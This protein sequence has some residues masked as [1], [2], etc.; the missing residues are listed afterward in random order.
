MYPDALSVPLPHRMSYPYRNYLEHNPLRTL[1]N[2]ES[3]NAWRSQPLYIIESF[4]YSEHLISI[5]DFVCLL[6]ANA[7]VVAQVPSTT[8]TQY[9]HFFLLVAQKKRRRKKRP[10]IDL[11]RKKKHSSMYNVDCEEKTACTACAMYM[12]WK[13]YINTFYDMRSSAT[14]SQDTCN[15]YTGASRINQV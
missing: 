13:Q 7:I 15:M 1:C 10:T 9:I 14:C 5:Y 11:W 4:F 6:G 2:R 8:C 3:Y 12:R